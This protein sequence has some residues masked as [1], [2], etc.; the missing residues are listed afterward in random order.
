MDLNLRYV[1]LSLDGLR[2]FLCTMGLFYALDTSLHVKHPAHAWHTAGGH[3]MLGPLVSFC[4]DSS[5]LWMQRQESAT[6][7]SG[8]AAH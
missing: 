6:V 1:A 5:V 7:P 4:G 3:L 8:N 2:V